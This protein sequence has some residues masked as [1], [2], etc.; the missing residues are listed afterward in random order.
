MRSTFGGSNKVLRGPTTATFRNA[1]E[2]FSQA[3]CAAKRANTTGCRSCQAATVLFL[4]ALEAEARVRGT[5]GFS[6][7]DKPN[8]GLADCGKI[9]V[10]TGKTERG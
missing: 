9:H 8:F 1:D 10:S 2:P 3:W 7:R 6:T 5:H 4:A